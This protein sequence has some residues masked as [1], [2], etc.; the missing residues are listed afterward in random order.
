MGPDHPKYHAMRETCRV[1]LGAAARTAHEQ[2]ARAAVNFLAKSIR[3]PAQLAKWIT[4]IERHHTEHGASLPDPR[5]LRK[6]L[7][8]YGRLGRDVPERVDALMGMLFVYPKYE[9]RL[10]LTFVSR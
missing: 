4:F 5:I 10:Q 6:P 8:N 7:R 1:L 9:T 3:G 2:S